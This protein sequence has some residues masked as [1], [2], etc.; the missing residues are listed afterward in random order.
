MCLSGEQR[1][2]SGGG[3]RSTSP[4]SG[5]APPSLSSPIPLPRPGGSLTCGALAVEAVDLVDTLAAVEAGAVGALVR[6]DLAEFP[7]VTWPISQRETGGRCLDGL[8]LSKLLKKK[9]QNTQKATVNRQNL[10]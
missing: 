9:T 8:K 3:E 5:P 7:L 10:I 6:I 4:P 2:H 1:E